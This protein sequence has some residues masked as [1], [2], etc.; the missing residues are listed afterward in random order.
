MCRDTLRDLG[1]PVRQRRAGS[2]DVPGSLW[3]LG[4]TVREYEVLLEVAKHRTN[5]EIA[6]RLHLSHRTVER[7]IANLLMKTGAENRRGLGALVQSPADP[8]P[9]FG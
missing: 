9:A 2:Q 1:E 5:R 8:G 3:N 6:A 4:I 7:H